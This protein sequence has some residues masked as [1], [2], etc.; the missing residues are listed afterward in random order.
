MG[1]AWLTSD[2]LHVR[3]S[4]HIRIVWRHSSLELSLNF[5][6][7]MVSLTKGIKETNNSLSITFVFET[8]LEALLKEKPKAPRSAF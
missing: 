4:Y 7:N 5:W 1:N 2:S 8:L 3:S 6:I